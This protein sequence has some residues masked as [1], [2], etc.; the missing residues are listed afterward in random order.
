MNK[1]SKVII[2]L[3]AFGIILDNSDDIVKAR[4]YDSTTYEII[5]DISFNSTEFMPCERDKL[6]QFFIFTW[7]I[8]YIGS[9]PFSNMR[10]KKAKP[11]SGLHMSKDESMALSLKCYYHLKNNDGNFNFIECE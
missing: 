11:K 10:L 9:K 4:I 1:K 5:D 6:E 7:R 8:G 3:D 2:K